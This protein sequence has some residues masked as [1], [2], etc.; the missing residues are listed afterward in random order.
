[1]D[2]LETC[3]KLCG[4]VICDDLKSDREIVKRLKVKKENLA[5]IHKCCVGLCI[6]LICNLN[7]CDKCVDV[8]HNDGKVCV[9]K[10]DKSSVLLVKVL[11]IKLL[12][13]LVYVDLELVECIDELLNVTV[14]LELC[15]CILVCLVVVLGDQVN[16]I[17]NGLLQGSVL[18]LI[19]V[20]NC[21]KYR[22]VTFLRGVTADTGTD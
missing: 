20:L 7:K 16:D 21:R 13:E 3:N 17:F 4:V 9:D 5:K 2:L 18:V 12:L 8:H 10:T 14:C 11:C 22:I 19:R 15:V 6:E 1:M